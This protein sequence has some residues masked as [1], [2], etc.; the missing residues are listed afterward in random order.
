MG[1]E[2]SNAKNLIAFDTLRVHIRD[3]HHPEFHSAHPNTRDFYVNIERYATQE[4]QVSKLKMS[5][6][7]SLADYRERIET[8]IKR[9][10]TA[11]AVGVKATTL[12][13]IAFVMP[14]TNTLIQRIIDSVHVSSAKAFNLCEAYRGNI[15]GYTPAIPA[16]IDELFD[17]LEKANAKTDLKSILKAKKKVARQEFTANVHA[18]F[19]DMDI[20]SM[21]ATGKGSNQRLNKR[22]RDGK[23]FTNNGQTSKPIADIKDSLRVQ[24]DPAKVGKNDAE[25]L[26]RELTTLH[27]EFAKST[28]VNKEKKKGKGRHRETP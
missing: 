3:T 2:L 19:G 17:E 7:E 20:V 14:P 12:S 22:G 18:N 27:P 23:P 13:F 25:Y 15:L 24:I 16:T 21:L 4:M 1:C 8:V 5:D 10:K 26:L 11:A 28:N 9:C 6:S